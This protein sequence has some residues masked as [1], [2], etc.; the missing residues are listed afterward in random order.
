MKKKLL[1]NSELV[2][3][4]VSSAYESHKKLKIPKVLYQYIYN[5]IQYYFLS[6]LLLSIQIISS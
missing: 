6:L 5:E 1:Y 2:S 3:C 4:L